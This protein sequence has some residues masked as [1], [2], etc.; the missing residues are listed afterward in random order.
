MVGLLDPMSALDERL[1][2]KAEDNWLSLEIN[3]LKLGF[4]VREPDSS[5][6]NTVYFFDMDGSPVLIIQM[7]EEML[8]LS[9][10]L[11]SR[12]VHPNQ[13][14]DQTVLHTGS[15][16]QEHAWTPKAVERLRQ[17]WRNLITDEGIRL[18]LDQN[19]ISYLE[20]LEM[21]ESPLARPLPQGSLL[22]LLEVGMEHMWPL[23]IAT[24]GAGTVMNWV[25]EI[26]DIA[27]IKSKLQVKG[28]DA[29]LWCDE[30]SVGP[31]WLVEL[32]GA[33][34]PPRAE[35]FDAQGEHLVTVTVSH[36]EKKHCEER[37][38]DIVE[39]LVTLEL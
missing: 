27:V 30:G 2:F 18:L 19:G 33:D 10:S 6:Y 4:L 1:L 28:I 9:Q 37:W 22:A 11:F 21:L 29:N 20:L 16:R 39:I 14:Q 7:P 13:A 24:H 25:G 8:D 35:F 15:T 34:T 36:T 5:Y 32:P 38:R 12:F 26:T 31:A 17:D 3:R 23:R